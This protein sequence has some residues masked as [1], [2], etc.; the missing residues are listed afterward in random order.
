MRNTLSK[1]KNKQNPLK[2]RKVRNFKI[3][4]INFYKILYSNE[5]I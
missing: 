1:F 5:K 4:K 3:I 2:M